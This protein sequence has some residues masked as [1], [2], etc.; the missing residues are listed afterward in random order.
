MKM[1]RNSRLKFSCPHCMFEYIL[2]GIDIDSLPGNLVVCPCCGGACNISAMHKEE[3]S[4][5]VCEYF[6]RETIH[7]VP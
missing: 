3:V 5:W 7:D 4:S 6:T 1:K 2:I